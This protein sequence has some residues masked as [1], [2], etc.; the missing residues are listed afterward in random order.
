MYKRETLAMKKQGIAVNGQKESE[1]TRIAAQDNEEQVD[2]AANKLLDDVEVQES[3]AP[4]DGAKKE[5]TV[6][7]E[8][9]AEI[10]P[11]TPQELHADALKEELAQI[12]NDERVTP[13]KNI[14]ILVTLFVVVLAV[15]VLKGGG[16]FRSPLGFVCGSTGFWLANVFMIL[17]IVVISASIRQFLLSKYHAKKRCGYEYVEGDIQWDERASIVYPSLCMFAGCFAGMFGVGTSTVSWRVYTRNPPMQ[18]SHS[19]WRESHLS[20]CSLYRCRR[21]YRQGSVDVGNGCASSGIVGL[22]GVHDSLYQLYSDNVICC[23]WLVD[24]RLRCNVFGCRFSGNLCWTTVSHVLDEE[25][26]TKLIHCFLDWRRRPSV[27]H[28]DDG[29][30]FA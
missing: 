16:A 19:R 18:L 27:V 20:L 12:L 17:W 7:S 11:K 22:V 3:D 28:I 4:A 10:A 14:N 8:K 9:E 25:E 21:W 23:F 6:P 30:V 26:P 13:R 15:N 2:E 29:T 5:A 1:L 24:S